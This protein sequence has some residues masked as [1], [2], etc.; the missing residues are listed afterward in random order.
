MKRIT[1][2]LALCSTLL[3]VV[4]DSLASTQASTTL[5]V[6]SARPLVVAGSGFKLGERVRVVVR[7]GDRR[8]TKYVP[9]SATRAF[10]VRFGTLPVSRCGLVAQAFGS[11]GSRAATKPAEPACPEPITP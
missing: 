2:L 6:V 5:R 3:L 1:L 11:L 9:V 8:W 10:S 7:Y 4:G